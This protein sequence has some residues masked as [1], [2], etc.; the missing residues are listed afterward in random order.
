MSVNDKYIREEL[1]EISPKAKVWEKRPRDRLLSFVMT[2]VL[3]YI[4]W[5]V[6]SGKI[7]LLLLVIGAIGSFIVALFS[8]NL[9]FPEPN[10][11]RYTKTVLKFIYYIPW[12]LLQIF[13]ANLHLLYLVFHPDIRKAINPHIISFQTGLKKDMSVVTMANSI[14][15]TPGTITVNATPEGYFKVHALD[16]PSARDLPGEMENKVSRIFED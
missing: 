2:F 8:N 7:E 9:L 13:I 16:I 14:T 10:F 12:L 6:L 5:F 1:E 4:L 15:L 11:G 3:M